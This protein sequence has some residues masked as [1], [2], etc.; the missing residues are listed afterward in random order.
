MA[1][2]EKVASLDPSAR[3]TGCGG[4]EPGA[5]V[6]I[7]LSSAYPLSRF[8]SIGF[9]R[10]AAHTPFFRSSTR[11]CIMLE[12]DFKRLSQ[13]SGSLWAYNALWLS[14]STLWL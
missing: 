2:P 12:R 13:V 7:D 11:R 3:R 4:R 1:C 9:K 8:K 6:C 14:S 10:C 5:A